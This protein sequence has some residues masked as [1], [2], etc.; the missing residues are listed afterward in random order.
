MFDWT[1]FPV[2]VNIY[3]HLDLSRRNQRIES[4]KSDKTQMLTERFHWKNLLQNY[5]D[6]NQLFLTICDKSIFW[7]QTKPSVIYNKVS[8]GGT[9]VIVMCIISTKY[10]SIC[11]SRSRRR[12]KTFLIGERIVDIAKSGRKLSISKFA[13]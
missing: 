4:A 7:P 8:G 5:H 6:N 11:F 3:Q 2:N 1:S 10:C 12:N 13:L 9:S